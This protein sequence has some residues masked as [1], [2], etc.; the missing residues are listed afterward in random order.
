MKFPLGNMVCT[1][2][3]KDLMSND[4]YFAKFVVDSLISHASSNWPNENLKRFSNI[5]ATYKRDGF[6]DIQI[7]TEANRS[8]TCV[9][10][11]DENYV[12]F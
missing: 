1:E 11:P 7:I 9:R 10:Y 8:C 6:P 12:K 5:Y 2:D 3:V 4:I